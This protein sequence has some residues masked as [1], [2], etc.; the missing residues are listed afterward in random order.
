M[1]RLGI[2]GILGLSRQGERLR[3]RPQIPSSW[4]GFEAVYRYGRSHYHIMVE[5]GNGD[6]V[7]VWLDGK[8]LP[9]ADIPLQDDGREHEVVI[10]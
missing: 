9:T 1:Y 6:E 4:P 2:E 3:I 7:Q 5:N 10:C 8:E